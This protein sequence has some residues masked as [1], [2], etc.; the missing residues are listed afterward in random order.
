MWPPGRRNVP[1][2]GCTEQ[3]GGQNCQLTRW[4]TVNCKVV[5]QLLPVWSTFEA[6]TQFQSSLVAWIVHSVRTA[7]LPLG[8][9]R[10]LQLSSSRG[11]LDIG[12][13]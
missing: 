13:P 10:V 6:A 5:F 2:V 1:A 4:C 3:H 7:V 11:H 9:V 12:K 8:G